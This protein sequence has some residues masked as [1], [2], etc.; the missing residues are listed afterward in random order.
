M[1]GFVLANNGIPSTTGE[2]NQSKT[3]YEYACLAGTIAP[4]EATILKRTRTRLLFCNT[5]PSTS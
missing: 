5:H 3:T 4:S 2:G 1:V